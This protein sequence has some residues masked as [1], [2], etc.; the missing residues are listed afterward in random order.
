MAKKI[1]KEVIKSTDDNEKLIKEADSV[2]FKH[3][4]ILELVDQCLKN[5]KRQHDEVLAE[6]LYK[7]FD[8][9]LQ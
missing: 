4:L 9:E 6:K 8:K 7:H 1:E 5:H 3:K 2:V